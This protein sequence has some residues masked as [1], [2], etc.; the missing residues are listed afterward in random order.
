MPD[1]FQSP[2]KKRG[3]HDVITLRFPRFNETV[4][5]DPTVSVTYEQ[6]IEDGG[7]T[8]GGKALRASFAALSAG[9]LLFLT[10]FKLVL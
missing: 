7:N 4:F 5:Y 9:L 1:G 3:G 6:A 2:P 10:V 8:L